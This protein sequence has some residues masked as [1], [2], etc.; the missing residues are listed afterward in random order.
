MPPLPAAPG[1]G[2]RLL[3][4]ARRAIDQHLPDGFFQAGELLADGGLRHAQ[5][6]CRQGEAAGIGDGRKSAQQA[7]VEQRRHLKSG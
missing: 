4:Y 2:E 7:G 1:C 6:V 3:G 5:A